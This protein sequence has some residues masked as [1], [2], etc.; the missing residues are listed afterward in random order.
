MREHVVRVRGHCMVWPSWKRT[1]TGLESLAS[2]PAAMRK[3]ADD[4]IR[5]VG[6]ALA[7]QVEEWDVVNEPYANNDLLKILGDDVMAEWF[8]A[9]RDVDPNARLYLNETG[10]P[11]SVPTDRRYDVLFGQVKRL[12]EL[13]APIGGIGMQ[14]HFGGNLNPPA[15]LLTIYD[16]FAT[17]GLPIRI[18]ELDIDVQDEQLQADYLRDFL[19]ASFSHPSINGILM[20]GFWEG[21]H[22]RPA[23]ALWRKDWSVKPAGQAWLDLV[24]KQWWTTAEGTS[25]ANGT[26]TIRSFLGDYTITVTSAGRT[27]TITATLPADGGDV[28]VVLK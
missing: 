21:E 13:G 16:R 18:T 23:A 8:K 9:A 28:R 26:F 6:K 5:V 4:H 25:T 27:Q 12:Q 7:G 19:T 22:W 15:N 24:R 1:P 17:L 3:R 11:T 20:W 2:D 14:A 10:V